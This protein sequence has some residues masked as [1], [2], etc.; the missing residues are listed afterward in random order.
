MIYVAGSLMESGF[1]VTHVAGNQRGLAPHDSCS[2]QSKGSVFHMSYVAG[3][4]RGLAS[5]MTHVA[6]GL[7]ESSF[8]MTNVAGDIRGLISCSGDLKVWL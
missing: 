8:H 7:L 1:H 2:Q 5:H 3:N 6:V 4:Q